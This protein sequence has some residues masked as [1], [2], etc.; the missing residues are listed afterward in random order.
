MIFGINA[1]QNP[2]EVGFVSSDQ[3]T[4]YSWDG[5]G[6]LESLSEYVAKKAPMDWKPE[7]VCSI[8]GPGNYTG[9]RL[10]LTYSKMV[11]KV[12]NV[13][14]LGVSLFEAYAVL[15]PSSSLQVITSPSR[16]GSFNVQVFQQQSQPIS[17]IV[18]VRVDQFDA[19][20]SRFEM[21]IDWC[22]FGDI[23][24]GIHAKGQSVHLDL[25]AWL[26]LPIGTLT[27]ASIKSPTAPVYSFNA[28]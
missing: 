3:A 25:L 2:I 11:S 8:L 15:C 24:E 6:Q 12:L 5:L 1:V 4:L 26:R 16:K 18:Q 27:T 20:I 23:P 19:W 13:P 9:I 28:A 22:H 14:L 17:S 10:A 7:Y 21:P